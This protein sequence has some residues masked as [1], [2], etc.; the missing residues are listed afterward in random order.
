MF[1]VTDE[2]GFLSNSR[3]ISRVS[4]PHQRHQGQTDA[5]SVLKPQLVPP[6]GVLSHSVSMVLSALVLWFPCALSPILA[7]ELVS[8]LAFPVWSL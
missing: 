3:S 7:S 8:D 1:Q 4:L 6:H 5:W 2:E